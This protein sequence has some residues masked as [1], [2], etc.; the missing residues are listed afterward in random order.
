[1]KWTQQISDFFVTSLQRKLLLAITTIVT[2]VMV[3]FGYYLVT[4]QRQT[5]IAELEDR[6]TRTVDLL[7]QTLAS[8]LW[9]IE[10]GN[11][12]SQLNAILADPEVN[13]VRVIE[14]GN[15]EPIVESKRTVSAEGP[16][17]RSAEII[18]LRG[19][20]KLPLGTVEIVYSRELLNRSLEETTLL[21]GFIILALIFILFLSIYVMVG[22][23]VT[24]PLHEMTTLTSRVAEGDLSGRVELTSRDEMNVLASAFNSMTAQLS[25]TLEGLEQSVKDRTNDLEI[26]KTVAEKHTLSLEAV[27]EISH[28]MASVQEIDEL[29]PTIAILISERY[30]FY[31]TGIYLIDEAQ[32][33]AVLSA[34]SSEAGQRLLE[35][36]HKLRVEPTSLVGY[37]ASRGQIHVATDVKL[38]A[39]YLALADLPDTRS[40]VVLPLIA[41]QR[42]IGVLDVQS[43]HP[44]AF[45]ERDVNILNTLA[46]LA[47]VSIQNARSF[48]ET[49]RAL[50]ESER[51][52]Q[53]FVEQG[54]GRIIKKN[55]VVGYKYSEEGL[56][57]ITAASKTEPVSA[58][59]KSSGGS[60]KEQTDFLSVPIKIREQV[61][62][63]MRI[64][65][66]KPAREWDPDELAMVQA[67]ADRAALALENA[68]LLEDS[69]RRATKERVISDISAKITASIS[70]D[71]ILKTAVEELGQAIPSA[72]VFVQFQ[73]PEAEQ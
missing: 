56:D 57:T 65:S 33:Y 63:T 38:D 12:E 2:V 70:M 19:E 11:L 24:N 29:L 39:T 68:R 37:A 50:A 20:E 69:Q 25:Q 51:I 9:N 28:S 73:N 55:P 60:K 64:R 62:G 6:A 49:R 40:E 58:K 42:I 22:R 8:P 5:R 3:G 52:Y 4:S 45:S 71:N 23:L 35:A 16:I 17:T 27:A 44:D 30:S 15:T 32:E 72:E 46:N 54:W 26:S 43:E 31:H 21:I 61:I 66:T 59:K 48:S 13:A 53:Q 47:A 41:G 67:T 14:T 34:T 18:Y 1:M 10:E 36:H 7:A